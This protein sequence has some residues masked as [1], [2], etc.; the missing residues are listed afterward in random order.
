MGSSGPNYETSYGG[1]QFRILSDRMRQRFTGENI[2]LASSRPA[3]S[4]APHRRETHM[5]TIPACPRCAKEIADP[6]GG[7]YVCADC[8]HEWPK[9]EAAACFL[10][11]V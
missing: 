11:K 4:G 5:S 7:N 2:G 9:S 3:Y 8:G 6:D 10:R 1:G